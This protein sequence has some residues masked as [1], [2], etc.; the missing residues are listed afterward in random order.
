MFTFPLRPAALKPRGFLTEGFNNGK[1]P[2]LPL[3]AAAAKRG[4]R[5]I[6]HPWE[7]HRACV[8]K[9]RWVSNPPMSAIDSESSSLQV[10]HR[11]PPGPAPAGIAQPRASGCRP[12]VRQRCRWPLER[13]TRKPLSLCPLYSYWPAPSFASALCQ[14]PP[15]KTALAGPCRTPRNRARAG[16]GAFLPPGGGA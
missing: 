1:P 10:T 9:P 11:A 8:F 7:V 3:G 4:K 13:K 12:A 5:Y 16:P 2:L 6:Y 14:T 15:R